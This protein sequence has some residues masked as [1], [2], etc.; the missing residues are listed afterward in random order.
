MFSDTHF[1]FQ[2][3]TEN[4]EIDGAAVL[5]AMAERGCVFGLDIGTHSDD[6][7]SREACVDNAIA[8]IKNTFLAD[9]ARAFTYFSAG[10]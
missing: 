3:F 9:K 8:Q 10:I 2:H 4:P 1:H 6:L 5:S 7:L